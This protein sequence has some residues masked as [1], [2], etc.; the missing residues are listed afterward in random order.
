[1]QGLSV[2]KKFLILFDMD[3][4]DQRDGRPPF[5]EGRFLLPQ[6]WGSPSFSSPWPAVPL[7]KNPVV[8]N[9]QMVKNDDL[10]DLAE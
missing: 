6:A 7:V 5:L 8:P 1:M 10:V 2:D 3:G 4:I 9:A